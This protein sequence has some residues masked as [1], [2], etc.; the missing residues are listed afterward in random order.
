MAYIIENVALFNCV[1]EAI[2]IELLR[3]LLNDYGLY[4]VA[5]QI[6]RWH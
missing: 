2:E 3:V 4:Y 6:Q 1:I 5:E